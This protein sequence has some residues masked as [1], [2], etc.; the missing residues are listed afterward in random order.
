MIHYVSSPPSSPSPTPISQDTF[1]ATATVILNYF[2]HGILAKEL[3][4][5]DGAHNL[6]NL[7]SLT[8]DMHSQFD[9]LGLW[10][11]ATE[12]VCLS[13]DFSLY[14]NLTHT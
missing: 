11:E 5:T 10:F 9:A 12:V 2:G 13:V 6:G 7:L 1:A 14:I 3:L 8:P 4:A